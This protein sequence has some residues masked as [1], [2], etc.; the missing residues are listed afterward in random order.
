MLL[1]VIFVIKM[2]LHYAQT[3]HP[4]KKKERKKKKK[5]VILQHEYPLFAEARPRAEQ[6]PLWLANIK[7]EWHIGQLMSVLWRLMT[8]GVE[9]KY[10]TRILLASALGRM[11]CTPLT[12]LTRSLGQTNRTGPCNDGD[13]TF[14]FFGNILPP[15]TPPSHQ[16][17]VHIRTH[18]TPD[19]SSGKQNTR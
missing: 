9:Y 3:L 8:F 13:N 10:E 16:A 15:P 19:T 7:S 12:S 17:F 6:T 1:A 14:G 18:E 5:A 11:W 4:P 2:R